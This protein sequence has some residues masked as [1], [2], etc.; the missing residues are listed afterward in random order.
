[1]NKK[2][3]IFFSLCAIFVLAFSIFLGDFQTL[4]VSAVSVQ[5]NEIVED[6]FNYSRDYISRDV[7]ESGLDVSFISPDN[8]ILYSTGSYVPSG[9]SLNDIENSNILL[10]S[11]FRTNST[12][13]SSYTAGNSS[14]HVPTVDNWTI[15]WNGSLTSINS[16]SI[17]LKFVQLYSSFR[18]VITDYS[19]YAGQ[20][21]TATIKVSN[22]SS[23]GVF[24][25]ISDSIGSASFQ[26]TSSGVFSCSR[27][28]SSSI[29]ELN[30]NLLNTNPTGTNVTLDIEWIKLEL[31][32]SFTGYYN[33]SYINEL[34]SAYNFSNYYYQYD[35]DTSSAITSDKYYYPNKFSL[36][37]DTWLPKV[38]SGLNNF[39]GNMVWSDG[40]NTYYSNGFQQYVL[41]VAT[42]TWTQKTWIGFSNL[43]GYNVWTD[44]TN[45]YYSN[46]N[47][48][49]VLDI[50][51]S[52]WSQM[53]W[54]GHTR[55]E[56][57]SI[58]TDGINYYF[59]YNNEQF[60]LDQATFTWS[61]KIWYGI[62][63]IFGSNVWTD[64]SNY[65]YSLSTNQY[66]LSVS[67][68][69]QKTW[70]G[71]NNFSGSN[72]WFNGINYCYSNGTQQYV[73]NIS[74]WKEQIWNGL[75][76]F[77]GSNVWSN[78]FGI[79]YSNG[80]QQY[81]LASSLTPVDSSYYYQNGYNDGYNTG[82]NNGYNS[83]YSIGEE[84]AG[85]YTFFSL[86]S[87]VI[88]AP[89]KTLTGLFNFDF[90]GVNLW[91]FFTGLFTLALIILIIKLALGGK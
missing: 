49:Y 50:T 70:N 59:S 8:S 76:N 68:W 38:W 19:L 31:G 15:N 88:D 71:L 63:N 13:L 87:S 43:V 69:A 33:S 5:S 65:Y 17:S 14:T 46:D 53:I 20:T 81:V 25:R 16:N 35:I 83:G 36:Q 37:Y 41:D 6:D 48:Q 61:D 22:V 27:V 58:W 60:V 56:G 34:L 55:F 51:T 30:V 39:N 64:G 23:S 29:T 10:N 89:I 45:Y 42:S 44:G 32:S 12:G 2:Y 84:N 1:M 85:N 91:S 18:Q 47:E 7:V 3:K 73:L 62:T 82:F 90:L 11:D 80:T 78:S 79:Y 75:N 72:I 24:L 21:L 66:F 4:F 57:H 67:T 54:Y 9:S 26:L 74:T 86:I 52:T 28:L 77:D 40:V